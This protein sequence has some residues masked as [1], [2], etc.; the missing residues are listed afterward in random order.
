MSNLIKGTT[1]EIDVALATSHS[2]Y[3]SIY[4]WTRNSI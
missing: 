3:C 2:T 4:N 1:Q